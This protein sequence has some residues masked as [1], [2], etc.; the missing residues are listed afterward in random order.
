MQYAQKQ[1]TSRRYNKN[2]YCAQKKNSFHTIHQKYALCT[3]TEHFQTVHHKCVLCTETETFPDGT[4]KTLF[5]D[6]RTSLNKE[7]RPFSVSP[8]HQHIKLTHIKSHTQ[9]T[10]SRYSL[11]YAFQFML[12]T[13]VGI[14]NGGGRNA[15]ND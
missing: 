10:H 6:H 11:M 9:A 15:S 8:I 3:D 12:C 5:K 2:V 7:P 13:Y 4:H 14:T 1:N